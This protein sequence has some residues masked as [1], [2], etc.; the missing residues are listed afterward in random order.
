MGETII[1]LT[2]IHK[3]FGTNHVLQGVDLTI[4]QGMV[5]TIIGRSGIGKSVLLK[6][7]IGLIQP[8][9]GEILFHN[10]SLKEMSRAERRELKRKFSYMFQQLALFDSM[11]VLEN[12]AMPLEETTRLTRMQIQKRALERIAQM[13]LHG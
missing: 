4:E 11:T 2:N 6:H 7:F 8:D 1:Q 12:V 9:E 13:D 5:T 3:S 10:R